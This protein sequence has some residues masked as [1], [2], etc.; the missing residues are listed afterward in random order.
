MEWAASLLI[1]S[2]R[3]CSLTIKGDTAEQAFSASLQITFGSTATRTPHNPGAKG[4]DPA[5]NYFCR[6]FYNKVV[7]VEEGNDRIGRLFDADDM[8]GVNVHL[9]L[10]HSGQKYHL[11]TL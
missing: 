2:T 6:F 10:V 9:L 1:Q 7:T 5:D 8:I 3:I 11:S 4:N